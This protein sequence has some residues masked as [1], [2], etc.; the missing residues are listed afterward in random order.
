MK[1]WMVSSLALAMAVTAAGCGGGESKSKAPDTGKPS[2]EPAKPFEMSILF[3]FDLEPPVKDSEAVKLIEKYTNTNLE[4]QAVPT[5]NLGEKVNVMIASGQMAKAMKVGYSTSIVNSARS[6]TFWDLGPYLK[7][8]PSL[9]NFSPIVYD[10]IKIDGKIYGVP[11]VRELSRFGFIYRKDWLTN[12]GLKEPTTVDE[13]YNVLKA[14]T[15]QDPDKNGKA[16]TYGLIENRD[17]FNFDLISSYFGVPSGLPNSTQAP[18]SWIVKD[19]K[20]TAAHTTQEYLDA[21]KFYKKLYDEKL[22]NPDFAITE[23]EQWFNIWRSGKAGMIK[24]VNRNGKLREDEVKKVDPNA[25]VDFFSQIKSPSGKVVLPTERGSNGF[26]VIPKASVKTEQELKQ[27]L[28]FLNK[29]A[30]EP[31]ATLLKWGV[32]GKHYE[33]ENGKVKVTNADAYKKEV[34]PLF[35]LAVG[36]MENVSKQTA[37]DALTEKAIKL[38][39]DNEKVAVADPTLTLFSQTYTEKG[40]TLE[41]IIIDARVKFILGNLNEAGWKAELER[42]KKDGGDKL[43]EEYNAAY[44]AAKK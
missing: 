10:N 7:D 3:N 19:G 18:I 36:D 41:K 5:A 43:T 11:I 33:L 31:M 32:Q 6:G 22:V 14:F 42:W 40:P 13:L 30:E 26:Y 34:Y 21:L 44:A 20:L 15:T 38:N 16:D 35:Q 9:N 1:K 4:L 17:L 2:A 25:S 27:V 37:S 24:Q 23:R 12:L 39:K 29:L 8:Y 28:G